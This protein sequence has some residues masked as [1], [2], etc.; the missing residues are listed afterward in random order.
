MIQAFVFNSLIMF[1][2]PIFIRM[3]IFNNK[4]LNKWFLNYLTISTK[5]NNIGQ[6]NGII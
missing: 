1:C 2:G 6:L 4:Y 3:L 5:D